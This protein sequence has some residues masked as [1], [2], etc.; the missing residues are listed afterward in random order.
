VLINLHKL[1]RFCWLHQLR[2]YLFLHCQNYSLISL[3]SDWCTSML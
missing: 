1:F 3:D 2:Y